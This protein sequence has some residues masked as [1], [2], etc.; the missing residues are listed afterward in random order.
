VLLDA[1]GFEIP[2]TEGQQVQAHWLEFKIY[3]PL[4]YGALGL[5]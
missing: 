4:P 3:N 1:N 5:L 2:Q